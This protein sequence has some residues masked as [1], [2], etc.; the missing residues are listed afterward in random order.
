MT[1]TQEIPE[2]KAELQHF[3]RTLKYKASNVLQSYTSNSEKSG[4]ILTGNLSEMTVQRWPSL[5]AAGKTS[6][7]FLQR[8]LTVRI[9][10]LGLTMHSDPLIPPLTKHLESKS[11]NHFNPLL[12]CI[13][14]AP[15]SL[16]WLLFFFLDLQQEL[17]KGD[18]HAAAV[19]RNLSAESLLGEANGCKQH[20]CFISLPK[21]PCIYAFGH[22]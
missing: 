7:S 6:S 17:R 16:K 5:L 8:L 4:Q 12:L 13:P 19:C 2:K 22:H 1:N 11:C 10:Y 20:K 15:A 18:I 14:S 21:P 3:P 9:K